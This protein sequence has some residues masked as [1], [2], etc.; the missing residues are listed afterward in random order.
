MLEIAGGIVLAVLFLAALPFIAVAAFYVLIF[1]GWVPMLV[2]GLLIVTN[3]WPLTTLD[4]EILLG[5]GLSAFG[6]FWG[7]WALWFLMEIAVEKAEANQT[8]SG[9]GERWR[10]AWLIGL[11]VLAIGAMI[12]GGFQ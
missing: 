10:W 3:R 7:V 2:V 8:G 5:L 9:S 1:A 11:L 12:A 6:A 4:L